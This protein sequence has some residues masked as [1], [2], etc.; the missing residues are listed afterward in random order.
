MHVTPSWQLHVSQGEAVMDE[1]VHV[2][3]ENDELLKK[4]RTDESRAT[5]I[6]IFLTH[7]WPPHPLLTCQ[8][9]LYREIYI[10]GGLKSEVK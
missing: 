2:W 7:V 6:I 1:D 9:S 10:Y 5:L 8:T 3:L 4:T